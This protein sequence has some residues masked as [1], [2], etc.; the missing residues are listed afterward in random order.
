MH[1]LPV[2]QSILDVV[3][4]HAERHQV[5]KIHAINLAIGA[6]SDLQDEWIQSYFD[7]IGKGTLAEGARLKIERVPVVFRCRAC[8]GEFEADVREMRDITCP[9][10]GKGDL[11]LVSGREYYIKSMEAE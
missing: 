7:Y 11:E 2:T 8:A 9:T 6:L 10:C 4:R 3:L 5:K 1:E